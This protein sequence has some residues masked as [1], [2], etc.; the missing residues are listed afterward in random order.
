MDLVFPLN[1][2]NTTAR[3]AAWPPGTND[4]LAMSISQDGI[5][6]SLQNMPNRFEEQLGGAGGGLSGIGGAGTVASGPPGIKII[7]S[8]FLSERYDSNVFFTPRIAGLTRE[9]YVTSASPQLFIRDN[10]RVVTTTLQVGAVGERYINNPAL[11]YIGYNG[12]VSFGLSEV[13]GRVFPG[14]T[15]FIYDN[16]S[17]SPTP[18]AFLGGGS[19]VQN[20]VIGEESAQALPV[21]DIYARGIQQARANTT[22]NSSTITGTIPLLPNTALQTSYTYAFIKFGAPVV[23]QPN[24]NFRPVLLESRT[25]SFTIGPQIRF[26][27]Q[28]I[29]TLGYGYF[30][31]EYS[32]QEGSYNSHGLTATWQHMISPRVVFRA[33][34]G[35]AVVSQNFGQ[36]QGATLPNTS[37]PTQSNLVPT[38]GISLAWASRTTN[39]NLNYSTGI[40]PSY[41]ASSGPLYS[42]V[43]GISAGQ[44]ITDNFGALASVNYAR[45]EA[46]ARNGGDGI[47]FDSYT[48]NLGLYYRVS[49]WAIATLTHGYG[50]YRGNFS[51]STINQF[52]RTEVIFGLTTYWQ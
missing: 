9:D 37:S 39:V 47:F 18:P 19:Q 23:S 21:S 27:G 31:S 11:S 52:N 28:D 32:G 45:N 17:Y 13:A 40:F 42:H 30:L 50:H 5:L 7:P 46:F 48:T 26:S 33:F 51:S 4:L 24:S 34:A 3:L 15:L 14:A 43:I 2:P 16:F 44:R 41:Q 22:T 8:L 38:G 29:L 20:Q 6:G 1:R 25:H 12:R 35:G 49:S 36:A 10:A